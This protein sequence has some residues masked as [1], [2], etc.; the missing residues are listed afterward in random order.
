MNFRPRS[1]FL[2]AFAVTLGL[3]LANTACSNTTEP[4]PA[5]Q[6]DLPPLQVQPISLPVYGVDVTFQTEFRF[7]APL[8]YYPSVVVESSNPSVVKVVGDPVQNLY[9]EGVDS[10]RGMMVWRQEIQF[11]T[12][13]S[14]TAN[15]TAHLADNPSMSTVL[16]LVVDN[17]TPICC[18]I[19][20]SRVGNRVTL[21]VPQQH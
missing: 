7:R 21:Y 3:A 17:S 20:S 10:T 4:N 2:L 13:S 14:G 6:I 16:H 18:G 15:I 19:S 5:N 1:R 9:A 11:N 12:L 8:R